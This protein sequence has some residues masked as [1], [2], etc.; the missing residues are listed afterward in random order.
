[1]VA[2]VK[3][4]LAGLSAVGEPLSAAVGV[5]VFPQDGQT[6]EEL[7]ERADQDQRLDKQA[8][9]RAYGSRRMLQAV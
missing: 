7:M 3:H 6:S 8:N 1:M 4:A 2:R 5:A 9:G